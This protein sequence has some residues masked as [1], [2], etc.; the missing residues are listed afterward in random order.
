M[1]F[2][3]D[4]DYALD[5]DR[6]ELRRGKDLICLAPRV[7][8]LLEYLIRN[9]DRVVTKDQLIAAVW[10]GRIVSESALTTRINAVRVAIRDTGKEQ[11][12]VKTLPRKGIRFIGTAR[13]D[14]R[15][16]SSTAANRVNGNMPS[17][18]QPDGLPAP[19][20]IPDKPSVAV[21]PFQNMSGYQDQ[22]YFSDGVTEDII[23]ELSRFSELFV[24][25]RNSSFQYRGG[26][27]DI[28][29]VGRELGVRYVLE[30]SVRHSGKRIRISAQLVD[31]STGV[32]R[33]AEH[34]DRNVKEVF[35][36]Q[37]EVAH[38]VAAL[39]AAHV[40]RAEI[41]RTLLKP[42]VNWQAYDYYLHASRALGFFLSSFKAEELYEAR[43]RFDK[44][45]SIDSDYARATVGTSFTYSIAYVQAFDSDHLNRDALDRAYALARR[46]IQLDPNLAEGHSHLGNVLRLRGDHDA[47]IA[48]FE[49][50][51]TLNPNFTDW[52][53]VAV[54]VCA[55]Q[56]RRAVEVGQANMRLD[57]FY[58]PFASGWFGLAHYM[59]KKHLGALPPLRECVSR[60]PNWAAGHAWLAAT[61]AQLGRFEEARDEAAEVLRINPNYTI[62]RTQ[63]RVCLFK[64]AK[65]AAHL[66]D[67]LRRA[68][69][70][71]R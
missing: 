64:H 18:L 40:K 15:S 20:A 60:A 14:V 71:Q 50:A 52:R 11:R 54:L 5:T 61:Y 41:E 23:T 53:F 59:L 33:W 70:P 67:G 2:F 47:A 62:E 42:P 65:D 27:I 66:H 4:E 30:G 24:I 22:E 43:H 55:G 57:P 38:T 56:S 31:S 10:R 48:E 16:A 63:K 44:S 25:A 3:F 13:E 49:R 6:R 46:A 35:S 51:M 21:L 7:F 34:Y 69:L 1:I 29:Q 12:L 9:R 39:L 68:S 45:L 26:S 28:R 32:H 17:T 37:D 58:P 19:L 8:D 36:V